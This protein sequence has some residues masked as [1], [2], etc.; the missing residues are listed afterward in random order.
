MVFYDEFAF[1]KQRV[2]AGDVAMHQVLSSGGTWDEAIQQFSKYAAIK[3]VEM[4][5]VNQALND[6]YIHHQ[7]K[8]NMAETGVIPFDQNGHVP[9]N[10]I[11]IPGTVS[12]HA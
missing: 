4:I 11:Q 3:Y 7:N 5:S 1:T 8:A 6:K 9:E 2:S 10:Y 12:S